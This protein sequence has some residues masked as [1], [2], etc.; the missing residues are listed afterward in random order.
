MNGPL[1]TM[2]SHLNYLL[3]TEMTERAHGTGVVK[4]GKR[5]ERWPDVKAA[6]VYTSYLIAVQVMAIFSLSFNSE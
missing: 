3:H 2:A 5:H 4:L 6:L 1:D